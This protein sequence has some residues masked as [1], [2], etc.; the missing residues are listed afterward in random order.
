LNGGSLHLFDLRARSTEL[1]D[2]LQRSGITISTMTVSTFRS[3]V[4]C[5]RG[6]G[7]CPG[8]RLISVGGEPLL[9]TDVEAFRAVFSPSCVLQNAMA[10]TE[11]RTYAQYFVP[12]AGAVEDPVPIGWSVAGKPIMLLDEKGAR[13]PEGE[14]GEI[15]VQ[16]HFL[17]LGYANDGEGTSKRFFPQEDGSV[18]YRTGDRG[19]FRSD[20]CL[21]FLGRGDSQVKI[22][23]YRVELQ[24]VE[25]ALS[26]HSDVRAAAVIA[27]EATPGDARLVAY[28][29]PRAGAGVREA[30]LRDY[31]RGLLPEFMV[32][33]TF[34]FVN[35]LPLSC[36][37]KLD[38][39]R[40]APPPRPAAAG[41]G[42]DDPDAAAASSTASQLT[43][44]WAELLQQPRLAVRERFFDLGGD[45]LKAVRLLVQIREQFQLDLPPRAL[46]THPTIER[47]AELID[48]RRADRA[49]RRALVPLRASG[50]RWPFFCV[51]HVGG[52]VSGYEPL[53]RHLG[54][55]RPFFGLQDTYPEGAPPSG[56]SIESMASRYIEEI[57]AIVRPGQPLLLGG[58]SLGA[59]IAFEMAQQ[60]RAAGE[61]VPLL[62][63]I[64]APLPNVP[65]VAP[66]SWPRVARDT[67]QNL[68]A[69]LVHDALRS[70]PKRLRERF[71]R[72]AGLIQEA[73]GALARRALH[74]AA[75]VRGKTGANGHGC[76]MSSAGRTETQGGYPPYIDARIRAY[77][78]YQP[79]SYPDR[80][81]L[82]C[83][84]VPSLFGRRDLVA[85][86][87]RIAPGAAWVHA[88]DGNHNT[89][90]SEPH[91]RRL[92]ALLGECFDRIESP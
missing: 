88:I 62:V 28:V 59:T 16:S 57:R 53:S 11:T 13:V 73:L 69:W 71:H 27:W 20:G 24:A 91:A 43:S 10:A 36:N 8:L 14:A 46:L 15:A 79:R 65:G 78:R 52:D 84:R 87:Q 40:L 35:D 68:P 34:L 26:G 37:G 17:A 25:A 51:H 81:V 45:S 19:R 72:R 50:T 32:P 31:V 42:A 5:C 61:P 70:D 41:S 39:R 47:L 76:A 30:A 22:R 90:M 18:V 85:R 66:R 58:F 56:L 60:L 38:R 6:P 83:A 92:A 3:L 77:Y 63:I 21:V 89:C 2:W 80:I 4:A 67:L 12:R 7:A 44:I 48:A 29:V 82:L 54:P 49:N 33:S 74:R 1:P 86:W 75:G 9:A 55:D 64:D 23:G